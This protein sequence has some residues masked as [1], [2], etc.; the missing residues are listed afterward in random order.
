MKELFKQLLAIW[1]QLGINQRVTI[2]LATGGVFAGLATLAFWSN[3]PEMQ[4]LYGRLSEKDVSEV[5]ATLQEQGVKYQLGG[6]GTS[7]YV[8]SEQV[9][10]MRMQLASKGLPSGDGVGF[11]IFDRSNFGISDFVQRTNYTRALQGELSRT[12][13]QLKGVRSARVMI[14]VP[15]NRL[16]FSETKSKPTASVFI[17]QASGALGTEAVNSIRFLVANS[18][19]GLR[20]DDVAVIDS[21]GNVLTENL[22]DDPSLGAASSQ[23]KYRKSVEDYFASKVETM[24]ANVVGPGNAVV[25]VSAD[26]DTDGATKT[27]ERYDPDGQ[28]LR[29]ETT[30]DDTTKTKEGD[31]SA[32]STTVG[33]TSNVPANGG[34]TNS[35]AE[36]KTSEQT[37]KTKTN[38]YEINRVT[39][40]TVKN[41]GAVT[42][43]TAAVFIASKAAARKPEELESLR[44][45]VVNALGIKADGAQDVA[46]TV[47]LE[48]VAFE[49]KTDNAVKSHAWTDIFYNSGDLLRNGFSAILALAIFGYFIRMLK[50]V[51]PDAIPIEILGKNGKN[52][53]APGGTSGPV[54]AEMLNELIRQ[55]PENVGAVLRGWM[56]EGGRKN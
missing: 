31:S 4:L 2:I 55:K 42:R 5:I 27:E 52:G 14:V 36:G 30:V 40:N 48:E 21:H 20:A 34:K 3:R 19:E 12:I 9:H 53:H 15:E 51:K 37:R 24:L 11:E 43:L 54:S 29:S 8:S 32:G 6:G 1:K 35:P 10:K 41:P 25:R 46:P 17:D 26:I 33:V 23:M 47:T 49:G 50:R 16:L 13:S 44:K 56:T 22:K 7:I 28:V 45:M 38:A 39:T 18:V